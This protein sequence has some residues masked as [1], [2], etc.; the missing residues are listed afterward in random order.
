MGV[1]PVC[2]SLG[3]RKPRDLYPGCHLFRSPQFCWVFSSCQVA[4]LGVNHGK[5]TRLLVCWSIPLKSTLLD[6]SSPFSC[7]PTQAKSHFWMLTSERPYSQW[8]N[9]SN[10]LGVA[11]QFPVANKR[12]TQYYTIYIYVYIYTYIYIICTVYCICM[13]I[14]IYIYGISQLCMGTCQNFLKGPQI[15]RADFDPYGF[16]TSTVSGL[17]SRKR[18]IAKKGTGHGR[19]CAKMGRPN[20]ERHWLEQGLNLCRIF[21][22]FWS[23]MV[24]CLNMGYSPQFPGHF[25]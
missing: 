22:T 5:F 12:I 11:S 10:H 1:S 6:C 3:L 2:Q 20:W 9:S 14:C 25:K 8:L 21:W 24:G 4:S 23:K 16:T 15:C 18:E 17:Q 7:W 19:W 13:Y